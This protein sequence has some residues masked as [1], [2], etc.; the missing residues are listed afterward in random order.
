MCV[1]FSLNCVKIR[2]HIGQK[3][4]ELNL[5][6]ITIRLRAL[7][8]GV[9]ILARA[10]DLS[11]LWDVTTRLRVYRASL[12]LGTGIFHGRNAAGGDLSPPSN[13]E[14]NNEDNY[15]STPSVRLHDV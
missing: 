12:F 2:S 9:R 15:T 11:V 1:K 13:A 8:S 3:F 6:N 7:R 5:H 14:V 10:R 4:K